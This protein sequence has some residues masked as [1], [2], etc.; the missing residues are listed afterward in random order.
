MKIMAVVNVTPDSFYDGGAHAMAETA[1]QHALRCIEDG[2]DILDI[3][4]GSTRPGALPV[5]LEEERARV[6]PVIKGIRKKNT[7]IPL[8]IDTTKSA[9]IRDAAP[10]GIQYANDITA[11]RA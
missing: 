7:Q 5:S 10:M 6:L 2:A 8:S 11:L 9:V 3:G 4:G 1:V